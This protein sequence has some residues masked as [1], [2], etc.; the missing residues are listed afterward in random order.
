MAEISVKKNKFTIVFKK[1]SKE[2]ECAYTLADTA[3]AMKWFKKI[4]HLK[5]IPIDNI[6]SGLIDLKGL[7]KIYS[8]FCNQ[9]SLGEIKFEDIND[10]KNLNHLHQIYEENHDK[11][12][13]MKDNSTLYEFHHAIHYAEGQRPSKKQINIA[14]G[15]K[16]GPLTESFDCYDYYSDSIK[17]NNIYLSWAELGKKPLNYWLDEEPNEQQRVN[18]LCKPHVTL[19]AKFFIP[20]ENRPIGKFDN[21]FVEW[22]KT[23]KRSWL[24]TYKID[25][26]TEKHHYSAPLLATADHNIDLNDSEFV[27]IIL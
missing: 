14:W 8:K 16:E 19:R 5:N 22:F 7:Q 18:E 20:L 3:I 17:E 4:K 9:Y 6:E 26:Y 21:S 25:S 23:F 1:K 13:R 2:F 24:E 11:I 27:K 12:S 10:Q 15:V